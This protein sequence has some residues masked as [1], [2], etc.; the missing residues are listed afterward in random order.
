MPRLFWAV[1]AVLFIGATAV[2]AA[3]CAGI[4][5]LKDQLGT[6]QVDVPKLPELPDLPS[7]AETGS[8][9]C[10]N[11]FNGICDEP[12]HCAAGTDSHDCTLGLGR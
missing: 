10:P 6:N 5:C 4:Q 7:P 11:A 1:F 3:D 2:G 9:S 12:S 8:N